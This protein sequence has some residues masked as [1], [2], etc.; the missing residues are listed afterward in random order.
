MFKYKHTYIYVYSM[1]VLYIYNPVNYFNS[2][3]QCATTIRFASLNPRQPKQKIINESFNKH[4]FQPS[5]HF[6]F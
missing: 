3:P 4:N 6:R 1:H 5:G 2:T